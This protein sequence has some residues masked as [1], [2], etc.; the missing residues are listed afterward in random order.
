LLMRTPRGRVVT[1]RTY[2]H[3]GLPVRQSQDDK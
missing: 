2:E 1:P 3:L